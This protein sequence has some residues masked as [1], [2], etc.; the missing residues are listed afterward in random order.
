[1]YCKGHSRDGTKVA[2]S[3][4]LAD[5]QAKKA[6]LYETPSLQTALIWTGPVNRKNHNILRK[7]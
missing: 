5:S 6:A 2:E 3:N 7:N 1:M 4:Q